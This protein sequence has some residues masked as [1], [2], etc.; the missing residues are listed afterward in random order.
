MKVDVRKWG[1]FELIPENKFEEKI[2]KKIWTRGIQIV[3][4]SSSGKL[5]LS[6]KPEDLWDLEYHQY[7]ESKQG[8]L[9]N[10]A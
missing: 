6:P 4:I 10:S 8:N 2:L 3:S 7:R 1:G 5:L 9:T